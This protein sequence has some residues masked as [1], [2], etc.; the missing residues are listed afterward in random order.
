LHA[1]RHAS[2]TSFVAK[3]HARDPFFTVENEELIAWFKR[4]QAGR[5]QWAQR[6]PVPFFGMGSPFVSCGS[7]EP[8]PR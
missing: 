6:P 1:I 3:G 4:Y 7:G 8:I 5:P 2:H